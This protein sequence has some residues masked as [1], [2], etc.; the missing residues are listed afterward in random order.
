MHF[1]VEAA[2]LLYDYAWVGSS[3]RDNTVA[4]IRKCEAQ[5]VKTN[6]DVAD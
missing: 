6:C 1:T 5:H 3:L 2:N 4:D